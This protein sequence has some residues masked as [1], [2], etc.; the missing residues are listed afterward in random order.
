MSLLR[1][2][3]LPL[4]FHFLSSQLLSS[5]TAALSLPSVSAHGFERN[6][7]IILQWQSHFPVLTHNLAS[8]SSMSIKPQ[9]MISLCTALSKPPPFE[10]VNAS[11]W[12]NHIEALL[13]ISG[14]SGEGC[15]VTIEGSAPVIEEAIAT[16]PFFLNSWLHS[17]CQFFGHQDVM[18]SGS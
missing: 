8:R 12:Y 2:V 4:Y 13:R 9:R 17:S 1:R 5:L 7:I 18:K 10:F 11:R 16:P 3:S 15:G 6:Y 14:V